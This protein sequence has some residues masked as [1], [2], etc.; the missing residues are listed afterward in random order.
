MEAMKAVFLPQ[1]L[2]ISDLYEMLKMNR[3]TIYRQVQEGIF[4]A[5]VKIGKCS[6]WLYAEISEFLEKQQQKREVH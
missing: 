2:N 4:P 5:P 1:Y 6:R 3:S